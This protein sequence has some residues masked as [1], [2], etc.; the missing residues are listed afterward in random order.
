MKRAKLFFHLIRHFLDIDRLFFS[1]ILTFFLQYDNFSVAK[2]SGDKKAGSLVKMIKD[3]LYLKFVDE[4]REENI[5]KIV[6]IFMKNYGAFIISVG[7][8]MY[9]L[10]CLCFCVYLSAFVGVC[11]SVCLCIYASLRTL[12]YF[13]V[14][15]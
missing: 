3:P 1:L 4:V 14:S 11:S 8:S 7:L 12:F 10:V 6:Y 5:L 2:L 13:Y 15:L 9:L